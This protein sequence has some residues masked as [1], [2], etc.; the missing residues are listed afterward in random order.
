MNIQK[1]KIILSNKFCAFGPNCIYFCKFLTHNIGIDKEFENESFMQGYTDEFEENDCS[2]NR[3]YVSKDLKK[4]ANNKIE[5]SVKLQ[6]KL[7]NSP[8]GIAEDQ[9]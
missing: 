4:P 7:E 1:V 9:V 8:S 3:L 2:V 5:P 6:Q